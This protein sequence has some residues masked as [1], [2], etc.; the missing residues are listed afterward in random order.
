M[1]TF[2]NPN[3]PSQP[4]KGVYGWYAQKGE[5][6]ITIYIGQAGGKATPLPKGTLFRGVSELQRNTF[7]SNS[8][9]YDA[10]DTDFIVGTALIFFKDRGY[11]CVWK[12][13]SNNPKEEIDFVRKEK[14]ILQNPGN[15]NIINEFK[16]K[17]NVTGH[18]KSSKVLL[19]RKKKITEAEYEIFEELTK[20]VSNLMTTPVLM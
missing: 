7:T 1:A 6:K 10:L 18:W 13:I 17:K 2:E 16:V 3:N 11:E 8:P 5:K 4:Q 20:R 15:T 19:E 12:H 14:P 9:D